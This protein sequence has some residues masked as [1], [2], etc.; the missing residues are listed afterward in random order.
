VYGREGQQPHRPAQVPNPERRSRRDFDDAGPPPEPRLAEP[1]RHLARAQQNPPLADRAAARQ[2]GRDRAQDFREGGRA[3]P[4]QGQADSRRRQT[5]PLPDRQRHPESG[6][7]VRGHRLRQ[8]RAAHG[9][10]ALPAARKARR[11]GAAEAHALAAGRR[12]RQA[13]AQAR[14]RPHLGQRRGRRDGLPRA[15]LQPDQRRAGHRLHHAR[16]GRRRARAPVQER[17][18]PDG[19]P[20]ARRGRGLGRRGRRGGFELRRQTRRHDRRPPGHARCAHARDC[21][22][23]DEHPRRPRRRLQQRQRPH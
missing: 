1:R 7:H 9:P 3:L 20:R 19:Q 4:T 22:H 21:E 12:S 5:R 13:R 17:D 10:R 2:V 14:R 8:T 16:Q 18:E 11:D 15:L 23:Q 6:R